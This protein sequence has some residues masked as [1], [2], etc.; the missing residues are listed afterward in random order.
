MTPSLPG[1]MSSSVLLAVLSQLPALAY[2]MGW[3]RTPGIVYG[4]APAMSS[5]D[6]SAWVQAKDT[7]CFYSDWDYGGTRRCYVP[8]E[9]IDVLPADV[10]RTF[11]SVRLSG[12]VAVLVYKEPRG[13]GRSVVLDQTG[14]HQYLEG[15]G[16][17]DA[18]RSLQVVRTA[19]ACTRD[20]R[21]PSSD[22]L[23]LD[24]L[25]GR[26]DGAGNA[27]AQT[28]LW[29]RMG[30]ETA[31]RLRHGAANQVEVGGNRLRVQGGAPGQRLADQPIDARTE[32]VAVTLEMNR[33]GKDQGTLGIHVAQL[34]R[35]RRIVSATPIFTTAWPAD[36]A[37]VISMVNLAPAGHEPV[38]LSS[39]SVWRIDAHRRPARG[40]HC[41]AVW[42]LALWNMLAGTCGGPR[43]ESHNQRYLQ[44]VAGEPPPARPVVAPPMVA[45]PVV[46]RKPDA[47]LAEVLQTHGKNPLAAYAASRV[48]EV[49][50][51]SLLALRMRRG[52]DRRAECSFNMMA[53]LTLYFRIFQQT[54]SVDHFVSVIQRIMETGTTGYAGA[55]ASGAPEAELVDAVRQHAE[56]LRDQPGPSSAD[57]LAFF[58]RAYR[59]AA[60][61]AAV[62][63]N[64]TP[65]PELAAQ[66]AATDARTCPASA[67]T[68]WVQKR[69]NGNINE[70]LFDLTDYTEDRVQP[71]VWRQA[72][73]SWEWD[74]NDV[75]TF[76]I[77]TDQ[78]QEAEFASLIQPL[79]A[80][81]KGYLEIVASLSTART[82]AQAQHVEWLASQS[83]L[84]AHYLRS[85]QS[86]RRV[87]V[88]A[89]LR[90]ETVAIAEAWISR[91]DP[92]EAT[93][94]G[95]V[96]PPGV[97]RETP[98]DGAVRRA[99]TAAVTR[100]FGWL[101]ER[102]VRTV[103][104][105]AAS[106]AAD[107]ACT[108]V[109][110]TFSQMRDYFRDDTSYHSDEDWERDSDL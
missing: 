29:F 54:N 81:H 71:Q 31:W 36:N 22:A 50:L 108:R 87:Y 70:Y 28:V 52:N 4:V 61:L 23:D 94:E 53:I 90:G 66:R 49:P 60:S 82:T 65:D 21:I 16:V 5:D 83:D 67:L 62:S 46:R 100:L 69:R 78:N 80:W 86:S 68:N 76:L 12:S 98:A 9:R 63:A 41:N 33:V 34:D 89:R 99:A 107:Q 103:V 38:H 10:D 84:M 3:Y 110:F 55:N 25:L 64:K 74:A 93:L 47:V 95:I 42:P 56:W 6:T 48:C 11:S 106:D 104:A 39:L 73:S 96:V 13:G 72:T 8:G 30:K 18:I 88:A 19:S 97:F 44:L 101:H 58:G 15:K 35:E 77:V 59:H 57:P 14:D 37:G 7:A 24:A 27:R 79:T 45:P 92:A 75:F 105:E 109:A 26:A 85:M 91:D 20:C 17:D 1:R 51:R 32:S 43:L 2:A 40:V 102:G